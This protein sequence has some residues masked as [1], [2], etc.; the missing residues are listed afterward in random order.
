[1]D[2][3][4]IKKN[5]VRFSQSLVILRE[6]AVAETRY[7]FLLPSVL[8]ETTGALA[9]IIATIKSMDVH[10][11]LSEEEE[12]FLK[13]TRQLM[14]QWR[15][16]IHERCAVATM[17][18]VTYQLDRIEEALFLVL[19]K[20]RGIEWNG[21]DEQNDTAAVPQ[22]TT[23]ECGSPQREMEQ[24]VNELPTVN[25]PGKSS[26]IKRQCHLCN[27]PHFLIHC[28]RFG[29]MRSS[30]RLCFVRKKQLCIN[31][32]GITHTVENCPSGGRCLRCTGKHHTKLHAGLQFL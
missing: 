14:V 5:N 23:A 11:E 1:M 13:V 24:P 32:Y 9:L 2:H 30:A 26:K 17:T 19:T 29:K 20:Q 27:E 16:R 8:E 18:R 12:N 6:V 25:V 22:P 10:R 15:K 4:S 31:C 21:D 3:S 28:D 7:G